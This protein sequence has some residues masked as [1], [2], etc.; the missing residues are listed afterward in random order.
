MVQQISN[1]IFFL[2]S[3]HYNSQMIRWATVTLKIRK[4]FCKY[5]TKG[6]SGTISRCRCHIYIYIYIFNFA[7]TMANSYVTN[8][9]VFTESTSLP[10]RCYGC[11]ATLCRLPL[12]LRGAVLVGDWTVPQTALRLQIPTMRGRTAG[13]GRG[14]WDNTSNKLTNYLSLCLVSYLKLQTEAT[15][16]LSITFQ[17]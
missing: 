15:S 5:F 4:V 13:W 10:W 2:K 9:P 7:T 16:G 8:T 17:A 3:V 1:V 6:V 12:S 14:G 11:P